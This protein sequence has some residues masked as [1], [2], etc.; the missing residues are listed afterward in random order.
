[1]RRDAADNHAETHTPHEYQGNPDALPSERDAQRPERKA[2][3][4]GMG[5]PLDRNM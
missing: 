1:M 2:K 5:E 4:W 3:T